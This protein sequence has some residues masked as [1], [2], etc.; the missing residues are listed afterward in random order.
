[1]QALNVHKVETCI[2]PNESLA[3]LIITNRGPEL[4]DTNYFDSEHAARGLFYLSWN[5]GVGRL[6]VPDA[7]L[8]ALKEMATAQYVIVS[9][10]PWPEQGKTEGIELLFED[11]SDSPY[12][13]HLSVEQCDRLLPD[14]DQGGGFEI[15]AWAR[16]GKTKSWPGKYRKVEQIPCLDPWSEH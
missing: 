1:M 6:L 9:R 11:N 16:N 12:C 7:S 3:M 13:L 4:A 14:L 15:V 2:N 10:G 5:A 8:P